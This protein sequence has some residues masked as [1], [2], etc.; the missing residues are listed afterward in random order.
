MGREWMIGEDRTRFRK[1]YFRLA[2]YAV[3]AAGHPK[4]RRVSLAVPAELTAAFTTFLLN[5]TGYCLLFLVFLWSCS[6]DKPAEQP[7]QT[8]APTAAQPAAAPL[9]KSPADTLLPYEWDSQVCHYT[10]RYNPHLYTK[11]QLD[12]TQ[13][14][15]YRNAGLITDATANTPDDIE[16]LNG[17]SLTAEYTRKIKYYRNLQVVPRPIWLTLKAQ[18]IQEL[19]DEYK[20]KKATIA[21][22]ANPAVLLATS[23]SANCKKYAQALAS[24]NDSLILKDWRSLVEERKK[25]NGAPVS[26][27]QRFEQEYNSADRLRYAKI[28]LLTYGWWNCVNNSIRRVEL[29]EKLYEQFPRL[30]VDV[31]SACEDVD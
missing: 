10:G 8:P 31:K 26:Y 20:A 16:K 11:E 21:G 1:G 3:R 12:N 17:D 13:L 15:L 18:A 24:H 19:E 4:M 9:A 6:P 22:F 28:E 27:M 2:F 7:A 30:F 14:L 25:L 5:R 23:Y 29:T